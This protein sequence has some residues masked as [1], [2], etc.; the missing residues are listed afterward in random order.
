MVE[1]YGGEVW[2]EDRATRTDA[3]GRPLADDEPSGAVLVV[4]LDAA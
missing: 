2:V 1:Q 4:E 3:N